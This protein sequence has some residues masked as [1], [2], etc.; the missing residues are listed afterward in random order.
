[1]L[2][3]NTAYTFSW[4]IKNTGTVKWD[5]SEYDVIF[6]SSTTGYSMAAGGSVYDLPSTVNP[7][8]SVTISGSGITPDTAGPYTENWGIAQ[9]KNV[10]CP[11][12]VTIQVK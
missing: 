10:I 6:V 3:A 4:V 2:A 9:G 12:Y 7:G 1:M 11:F 8:A 5:Q